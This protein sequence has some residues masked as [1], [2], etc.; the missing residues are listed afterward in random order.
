MTATTDQNDNHARHILASSKECGKE[1]DD[2]CY[3][4]CGESKTEFNRPRVCDNHDEL[5]C[6]SKEKEKV[7]LQQRNVD[8]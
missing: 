7:K 4:N 2:N 6:E 8:L 5:D 1:E 3:G